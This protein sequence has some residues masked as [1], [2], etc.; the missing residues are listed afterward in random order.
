MNMMNL[1][2][3][4]LR[5]QSLEARKRLLRISSAANSVHIGSSL[6]MI[7]I[8][9]VLYG[10]FLQ[11]TPNSI[12]FPDRDKFVLS[13]GHAGLGLYIILAQFG[14]IKDAEVSD[15]ANDGTKLAVHPV[16]NSAPG[17][18]ATSGSL[19]H[20]L[21]I[22]LGMAIAGKRNG[23][24]SRYVVLMSDGECDEGSNWE[25]IMLAGHLGLDNLLVI[26]DYNK[27]Q[28]F[29][30]T[31]EV[32]ELEPFKDKWE[33]NRWSVKEVDGHDLEQLTSTF[34]SFPF[35]TNRPS[36]VIAHTIKGKGVPHLENTLESHY[37]SVKPEEL[38]DV[39]STVY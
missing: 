10:K 24:G 13:K 25:A 23:W 15:Y 29:G 39:L 36:V 34:S 21:P 38:D 28:S 14:F 18:E 11:V 26:V 12:G 22:S 2:I 20:G 16:L 30:T 17:I 9:E 31:S 33:A 4:T 27:I 32:L 5:E 1:S 6:S 37:R 19:G 7:E 8:L 3:D 35:K